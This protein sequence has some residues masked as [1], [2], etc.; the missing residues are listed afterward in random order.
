MLETKGLY[1]FMNKKST[2]KILICDDE[3][4]IRESLKFILSDYY[5][6]IV[7]DSEEQCIDCLR[8]AKDIGLL[9]IDENIPKFNDSNILN[10]VKKRYPSLPW[11]MISD[12]KL[13]KSKSTNSNPEAN[14]YIVKPF[15]YDEILQTAKNYLNKST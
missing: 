1:S 3:E 15:K 2:K 4:G 8:N 7:T 10:E 9:L 12:Y 6:L 13:I 11:I 14:K 5:D